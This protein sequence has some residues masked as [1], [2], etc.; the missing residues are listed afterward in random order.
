MAITKVEEKRIKDLK[1]TLSNKVGR[2]LIGFQDRYIGEYSKW[3]INQMKSEKLKLDKEIK[4]FVSERQYLRGGRV[5]DTTDSRLRSRRDELI[6]SLSKPS[7]LALNFMTVT[8]RSYDVKFERLIDKLVAYNFSQRFLK[9][10]TVGDAGNELRFLIEN[11]TYECE[12]RAI[13]CEGLIN[14]PHYRF[15]TTIRTK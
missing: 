4:E 7:I 13:F 5:Y 14:A 3:S 11:D 2:V 1:A 8:K 15:I 9:V 6:D 10:H 12:A